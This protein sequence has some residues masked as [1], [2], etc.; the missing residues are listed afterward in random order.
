VGTG[1]EICA[2]A[3]SDVE[4]GFHS[5]I[6]S[7]TAKTIMVMKKI[8]PRLDSPR[9]TIAYD[10]VGDPYIFMGK[11]MPAKPNEMQYASNFIEIGRELVTEVV[12]RPIHISA[13]QTRS[14]LEGA[15]KGVDEL[16]AGR[17]SGSKLVYTI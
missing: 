2:T 3:M 12:V 1:A 10:A 17:A 6:N 15:L 5:T 16:R 4:K 14:G 9:S 11:A 7:L 8:N 13:N